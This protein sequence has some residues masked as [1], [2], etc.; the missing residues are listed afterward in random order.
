MPLVVVLESF[1]SPLGDNPWILKP[2]PWELWN[3]SALNENSGNTMLRILNPPPQ[4]FK[5]HNPEYRRTSTMMNLNNHENASTILFP[6]R[7][8]ET[9]Q[10]RILAQHSDFYKFYDRNQ[11]WELSSCLLGS[12]WERRIYFFWNRIFSWGFSSVLWNGKSSKKM[13]VLIYFSQQKSTHQEKLYQVN[14]PS[15]PRLPDSSMKCPTRIS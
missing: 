5:N 7:I 4:W 14:V 6:L 9:S 12:V 13:Y 3:H 11:S 10:N 2:S 8:L 1:Q 15:A